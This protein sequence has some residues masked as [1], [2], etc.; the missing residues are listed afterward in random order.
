VPDCDRQ[1]ETVRSRAQFKAHPIH[2]ALIPFPFAFLTAAPLFDLA[3]HVWGR[4]ELW[5]TSGH[6]I[7][8][9][10]GTGLLAAIPG[11]IDYVYAVPPKSSG[12]TRAATHALLNV[13]AL[14]LFAIA[15]TLRAE[16]PPPAISLGLEVLGAAMLVYSGLLG[17]TLVIR[18]MIGVDHRFADAGK[19]KEAA[20]TAKPGEPIEVA[21]VDE[22]K[23]D[24]M[25]LLR[26]NGRRIALARTEQGYAAFDD[27]CTHR[28][29]SL[30]G[31]VLI[32][33]TVQCLWHGSQFDVATG[34][35]ACGPAPKSIGVY[36]VEEKRGKVWL[37]V[38]RRAAG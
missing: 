1:E 35:V 28:G 21:D 24:Q 17:G 8:A 22:L 7:V 4:A 38:S 23:E 29:G 18:N 31:G 32:G 30:A 14:A 2:P 26:V 20:F 37:T 3:G 6:L 5:A 11:A 34:R 25:M 15:W 13:A 19:W 16:G 10:V 12:K 27:H 36:H 33:G 9:G